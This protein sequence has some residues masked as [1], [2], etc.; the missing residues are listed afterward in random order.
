MWYYIEFKNY[1]CEG[2][3]LASKSDVNQKTVDHMCVITKA[4]LAT[5][6]DLPH[7][8]ICNSKALRNRAQLDFLMVATR[9][10]NRNF[11]IEKYLI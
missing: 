9:N 2:Y 10:H 5:Y 3:A 1:K 6:C 8:Q 11:I 4:W 7:L